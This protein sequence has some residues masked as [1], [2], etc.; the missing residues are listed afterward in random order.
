MDKTTRNSMSVCCEP[1]DATN[2]TIIDDED[3]EMRSKPKSTRV[4][5]VANGIVKTKKSPAQIS[6]MESFG[7]PLPSKVNVV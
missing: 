5:K 2:E 3:C 6:L 4:F 1:K 7:V